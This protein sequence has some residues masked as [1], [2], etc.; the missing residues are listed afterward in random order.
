MQLRPHGTG[1]ERALGAAGRGGILAD[2]AGAVSG[3]VGGMG[4]LES[5]GRGERGW[6]GLSGYRAWMGARNAGPGL[7]VG[8]GTR[9]RDWSAGQG[10]RPRDTGPGSRDRGLRVQD[11]DPGPGFRT[12]TEGS[13]CGA[14]IVAWSLG[15]G[16]GIGIRGVGQ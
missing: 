1:S 13:H 12:R 16:S 15:P 2:L 14:G 6:D 11:R 3:G 9:V 10:L 8:A 7:G 4:V 5:C